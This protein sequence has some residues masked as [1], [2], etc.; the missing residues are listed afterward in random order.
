MDFPDFQRDYHS[1]ELFSMFKNRVLMP[2]WL[3]FADS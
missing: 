3:D 1:E 2:G